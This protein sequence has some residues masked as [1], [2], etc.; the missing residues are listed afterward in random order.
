MQV[1]VVTIGQSPRIDLKPD[2]DRIWGAGVDV[3]ES[4]AL[5]DLSGERIRELEPH[6][7]EYVLVSRLRDG[8]Q[9]KI[10]RERVAP[11]L[12]EKIDAHFKAGVPVAALMCSCAFPDVVARGGLLLYP[13]EVL[14]RVVQAVGTGARLGVLMPTPEQVEPATQKWRHVSN[15]LC[16][17]HASPYEDTENAIIRAA[18][19]FVAWGADLYVMDCMGFSHWMREALSRHTNRPVLTAL[20]ATARVI[21]ELIA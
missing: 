15:D 12:Q 8:T 4:G 19:R 17:L 16:V 10:S 3:V 13:S 9:V 18:E 14:Y 7:G 1:A 11:L 5:D 20:G 6:P 2:L 21:A